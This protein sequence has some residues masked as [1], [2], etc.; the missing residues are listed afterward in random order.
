MQASVSGVCVQL[1]GMCEY[2]E[3]AHLRVH[4]MCGL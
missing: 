3:C 1:S 2:V 4:C